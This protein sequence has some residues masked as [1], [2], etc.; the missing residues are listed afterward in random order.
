VA[1]VERDLV[2][3]VA[4]RLDDLAFELDL[5]FLFCDLVPFRRKNGGSARRERRALAN[6]EISWTLGACGPFA[7][8]STS[9]VT[10]APSVS[11]LKPLPSIALKWTKTSSPPSSCAMKP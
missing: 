11:D 6:A 10:F 7:P 1:V 9:Y 2:H 8:A 4:I 5:L 3:A